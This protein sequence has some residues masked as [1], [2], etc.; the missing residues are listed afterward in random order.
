MTVLA[1]SK[2]RVYCPQGNEV[3]F[4]GPAAEKV[5]PQSI[6]HTWAAVELRTGLASP[7]PLFPPPCPAVTLALLAALAVVSTATIVSG[8]KEFNLLVLL[9]FPL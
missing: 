1:F 9:E 7:L 3:R 5:K 4:L 2:P 6:V 8:T